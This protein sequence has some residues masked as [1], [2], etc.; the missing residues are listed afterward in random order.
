MAGSSNKKRNS[1]S[2]AKKVEILTKLETTGKKKSEICKDFRIP[3]STL[4]TIIKNKQQLKETFAKHKVKK[5]NAKIRFSKYEELEEAL[6]MWF[7]QSRAQNLPVSGPLISEKAT[8]LANLLKLQFTPNPAWLD[9][10]KKRHDIKYKALCGESSNVQPHMTEGWR[11]T[12]LP[13]LLQKF[14]L[15][16]IFNCDEFGLFFRCLPDKTMAFKEDK[17]YGGKKSKERITVL[18]GC[19]ADGSEKLPLLVIGKSHNPRCFKYAKPLPIEYTANRKAWMTSEIFAAWLQKIDKNFAIKERK[20]ALVLDNCTAH[21]HIKLKNIELIFLP[22]NTTSVL[23]PCDQGIIKNVKHHYRTVIMRKYLSAIELKTELPKI[24]ILDALFILKTAW[25]QVKNTTIE[26]CFRHCGFKSTDLSVAHNSSIDSELNYD[27]LSSLPN[28][29]SFVDFVS[30]D[31]NVITTEFL[32]DDDIVKMVQEPEDVDS[33]D[34]NNLEETTILTTPSN[35][36]VRKGLDTIKKYIKSKG[37]PTELY[38]H[39]F[40]LENFFE[41]EVVSATLQTKITDFFSTN[42]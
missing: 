12:T 23:Q 42:I 29:I 17:C 1:L 6:L 9:R 7:C 34:N 37:S 13:G 22:P 32:S 2:I 26:N 30:M 31:D 20:V 33:D 24:N 38:D 16:D 36:D 18:V 10:F 40:E 27:I 25:G 41:K 5:T 15:C 8:Q 3:K 4:S 39:F 28:E 11:N 35:Q 21:P 19:N 14:A